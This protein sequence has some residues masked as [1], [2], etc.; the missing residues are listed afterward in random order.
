MSIDR[1]LTGDGCGTQALPGRPDAA[2]L[3]PPPDGSGLRDELLAAQEGFRQR[4]ACKLSGTQG[5]EDDVRRRATWLVPV[6]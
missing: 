5:A 6:Q 2:F 1:K 3:A 4:V